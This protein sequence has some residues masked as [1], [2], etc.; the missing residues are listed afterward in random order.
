LAEIGITAGDVELLNH[1]FSTKTM[2]NVKLGCDEEASRVLQASLTDPTI[3]CA[4]SSLK[5]LRDD[6]EAS[7]DVSA[8]L[9]QQSLSYD[10]GIQQYCMA[11]GG[12]AS[13]LSSSSP[14]GLKSALFCCQLFISIEQVRGNYAVMAQHIIQGLGIMHSYRARPRLTSANKLMPAYHDQ[15]PLLDVFIIKLFAAPCK[16]A[17]PPATAELMP[18]MCPIPR[19]SEHS[20]PGYPRNIA[21]DTRTKL[22]KIATSTIEFLDRVSLIG[23][24]EDAFQLRDDKACLL[25]SL[26]SWLI[27]L[28]SGIEPVSVSFMRLFHQVLKVVLLWTLD[29]SP[30][31]DAHVQAENNLL[32]SAAFNVGVRVKAYQTGIGAETGS[33]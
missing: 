4:I 26:D 21:P 22:T 30:E 23:S 20:Q 6:F 18:S 2:Y 17:E 14:T 15:L 24:S 16:F 32:Q 19:Q 10:H 33:G 12:T 5:A 31:H 11:L 3:R 25:D 9:A 28:P 27:E 8:P 1:C 7:G 13:N 29:F